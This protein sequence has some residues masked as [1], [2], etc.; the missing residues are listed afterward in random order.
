M[1]LGLILC[2][3]SAFPAF[4]E[5][6]DSVQAF[7]AANDAIQALTEDS[8]Q[9]D[10]E[11]AYQLLEQI[12]DESATQ[13]AALTGSM[14]DNRAGNIQLLFAQLQQQ[15]AQECKQQAQQKI[16]EITRQQDTQRL[17]AEYINAARESQNEAKSKGVP[18]KMP[19]AMRTFLQENN[20][21]PSSVNPGAA[22]YTKE[23]WMLI[24]VSLESYRSAMEQA[25][26]QQMVYIQ[27]YMGQYNQYLQG[28]SGSQM[29]SR[30]Q[31]MLGGGSAGMTVTCLLVGAAV[32]AAVT[33][34]VTRKRKAV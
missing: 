6:S 30:S 9:E 18:Q 7:Q 1:L 27:D 19:D 24:E 15:M 26:Q 20:L 3:M 5:E 34:V 25:T 10:W 29:A 22:T 21:F 12:P 4:A 17:L 13:E 14:T 2:L 28:V 8:T 33:L 23:E 32:G 31:T 16:Q 11:R